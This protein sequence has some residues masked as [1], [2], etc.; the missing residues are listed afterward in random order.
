MRSIHIAERILGLVT[1]R[2]RAASIA[3][4]LAE[5]AATRGA[6]WFWSGV[7]HTAASLVW[8]NLAESPA[9]M[10][11]LAFLGLALEIALSLLPIALIYLAAIVVDQFELPGPP[12]FAGLRYLSYPLILVTPILIGRL[13]AYRAP[14][15]ELS[16]CLAYAILASI[17]N[18]A[19]MLVF[20]AG[21]GPSGILWG[22]S[23]TRLMESHSSWPAPFGAVADTSATP[24]TNSE[25]PACRNGSE[26]IDLTYS[27]RKEA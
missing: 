26:A 27:M 9:R 7:T 13:L 12:V 10:T 20:P 25:V 4:D 17:F 15:R 19:I 8:R 3:G 18:L 24:Q 22:G 6:R 16:A 21:M 2:D 14:G 1:S 11:G 5:E 23:P